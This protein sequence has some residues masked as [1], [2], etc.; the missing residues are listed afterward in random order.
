[1][2]E[3]QSKQDSQLVM[4]D[5]PASLKE[6]KEI[7]AP[8]LTETE[9]KAFVGLG[10]G[11]G[12][13]PFL[14]EIYAVKYDKT[15]PAT[16][17]IA[18]DGYR[19]SSQAHPDYDYH[20]TSAIYSNDT[21]ENDNG[22]INH[23]YGYGDRG[24]LLGAYCMVKR[25]SAS[26]PIYVDVPLKEYDQNHSCWRNMKETMIKKVAEAQ[27][28]KAA[29]QE[30]FSG[31]MSDDEYQVAKT[32]PK[33]DSASLKED[34]LNTIN[35]SKGVVIDAEPVEPATQKQIETIEMLIAVKGFGK[36]RVAKALKHYDVRDLSQLNAEQAI[37]FTNELNKL[38]DV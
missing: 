28:L 21:F 20:R 38:E 13:N 27:C 12:L 29:F 22:K 18:R 11:T 4:W 5:E 1:M 24:Q 19:K 32:S 31:S 34:L 9:F 30:L 2:N 23:K 3:L 36:D 37:K 6:I 7:F 35:Q 14:K 16:F 33:Q 10:K 26:E 17:I 25:K 15:K 8:N